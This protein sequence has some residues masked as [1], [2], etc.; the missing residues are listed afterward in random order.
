MLTKLS[1]QNF[2]IIKNI[3]IEFRHGLNIIIGETGSGKSIVIEALM[4]LFG[5]KASPDFVRKD[6]TKAIIEA[7]FILDKNSILLQSLFAADFD[8]EN[9]EIIIRREIPMKG[10]SRCFINDTPISLAQLRDYCKNLVDFHGQNEHQSLLDKEKQIEILDNLL[11]NKLVRPDYFACF[12]KYQ[13]AIAELQNLSSKKKYYLQQ[14]DLFSMQ[15]EEI[16]NI[17]PQLDE[18]IQIENELKILDNYE[19]LFINCNDFTQLIENDQYSVKNNL[20]EC[21]KKLNELCKFDSVFEPYIN[22]LKTAII[23]INEAANFIKSYKNNIIFNPNRI[24]ELRERSLKINR[25]KKKHGSIEEI[26][27]LRKKLASEIEIVEHYDDNISK[28]EKNIVDI[29]HELSI[30]ALN[31]H[32]QRKKV[33]EYLEQKVVEKLAELGIENSIFEVHISN[34]VIDENNFSYLSAPSVSLYNKCVRAM[35]TGIDNIEFFISTNKGE[36]T[37]PLSVVASGGEISRIMLAMKSIIAEADKTPILIF[38]EIDTGISGRIAQKVGIAMKE[39]SNYHQIIAIT[40]LPQ[41][42][43]IGSNNILISKIESANS[44]ATIAK[45]LDNETKVIEIAKMLSG[46]NL[47]DAAIESAKKLIFIN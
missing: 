27:E 11:Q 2:V 15:I 1:I 35:P 42:A 14:S 40:H 37:E 36:K 19:F 12:Q 26:L 45:Q 39:L 5:D 24:E 6:S 32:N 38:D 29:R 46:E 10:N 7:N 28:L 33:A 34:N 31:L 17:S 18:D 16:D 23:S 20:H 8:I 30:L 9:N 43:A 13:N 3:E 22:E 47:S 25:L 4:L 21:E 41:I 44:V